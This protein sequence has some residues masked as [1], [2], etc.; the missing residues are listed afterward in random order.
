MLPL[1]QPFAELENE[2][3]HLKE[4]GFEDLVHWYKDMNEKLLAVMSEKIKMERKWDSL[5]ESI[6][7]KF[8]EVLAV[9]K[10]CRHNAKSLGQMQSRPGKASGRLKGNFPPYP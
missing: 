9:L 5:E 8:A 3:L 2:K 7:N 1:L 10:A 4:V 6:N